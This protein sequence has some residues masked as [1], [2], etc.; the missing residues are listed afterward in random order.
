MGLREVGRAELVL[1]DNDAVAGERVVSQ[2]AS[3]CQHVPVMEVQR[4]V[5]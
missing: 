1:A 3:R 4:Q 5:A 2:A